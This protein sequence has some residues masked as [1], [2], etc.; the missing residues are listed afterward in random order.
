M[1]GHM[2]HIEEGIAVGVMSAEVDATRSAQVAKNG[3]HQFVSIPM[4]TTNSR[5][6]K[7]GG[8]AAGTAAI[9]TDHINASGRRNLRGIYA[10]RFTYRSRFRHGLV[11]AVQQPLS[12]PLIV[13]CQYISSTVSVI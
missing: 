8:E 13:R 2:N 1:L 9:K 7:S 10:Y 4:H 6:F 3:Q 11:V 12:Y 5:L